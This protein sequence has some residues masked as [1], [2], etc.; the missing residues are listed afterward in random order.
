MTLAAGVILKALHQR[1]NF[2]SAAVYLAQSSANLM[3]RRLLSPTPYSSCAYYQHL[4]LDESRLSYRVFSAAG[5]PEAPL[6]P[7]AAH[8][9]RAALRKGVVCRY[10]DMSRHDHLPWRDR[11]LVPG[12][13]L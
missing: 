1:P 7:P 6:R 10:R 9:N 12:D 4:D 5:P 2:Y 8:R 13:V 11:R 3:V